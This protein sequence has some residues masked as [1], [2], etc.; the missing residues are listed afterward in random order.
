MSTQTKETTICK[1]FKKAVILSLLKFMQYYTMKPPGPKW[2]N[3]FKE[4][5]FEPWTAAST[6]CSANHE[7]LIQKSHCS[8]PFCSYSIIQW[9][10]TPLSPDHFLCSEIPF[11]RQCH[12]RAFCILIPWRE[13][14]RQAWLNW[15]LKS[16]QFFTFG[17][18]TNEGASRPFIERNKYYKKNRKIKCTDL[19]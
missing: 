3:N 2:S 4:V 17:I 10:L 15:I 8:A 13:S 18:S 9:T 7:D 16:I 5:G 1:G 12:A 11:C 6:F 14:H 19:K